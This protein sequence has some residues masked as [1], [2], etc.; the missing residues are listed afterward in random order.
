M[1]D[2]EQLRQLVSYLPC[3]HDWWR[4]RQS[5]AKHAGDAAL[6]TN[7]LCPVCRMREILERPEAQAESSP[8]EEPSGSGSKP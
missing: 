6:D 1:T 4:A 3:M 7:P 8:V 5:A 2:R